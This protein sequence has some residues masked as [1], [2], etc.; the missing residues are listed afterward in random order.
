MIQFVLM[1]VIGIGIFIYGLNLLNNLKDDD[2][3]KDAK[4]FGYAIVI[5]V[6]VIL[7]STGVYQI[8]LYNRLNPIRRTP[9]LELPSLGNSIFSS[10]INRRANI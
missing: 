6:G 3:Y 8:V 9:T 7:V 1:I 2:Q 5:T 10:P 4:R